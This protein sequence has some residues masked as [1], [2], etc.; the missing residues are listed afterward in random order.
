MPYCCLGG[1]SLRL[2]DWPDYTATNVT[3]H[4]IVVSSQQT[5]QQ[6]QQSQMMGWRYEGTTTTA[7][8]QPA[9][10]RSL[11]LW[12]GV[13]SSASRPLLP[14]SRAVKKYRAAARYSQPRSGNQAIIIR[15][16]YYPKF[17]LSS[18]PKLVSVFFRDVPTQHRGVHGHLPL[19]FAAFLNPQPHCNPRTTLTSGTAA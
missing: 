9:L 6:R 7:W 13:P 3:R 2:R 12:V 17:Q 5:S 19:Q 10:D 14:V 16:P 15:P 18:P 11:I 4:G 8:T 1:S